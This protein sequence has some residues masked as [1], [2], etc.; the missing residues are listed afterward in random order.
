MLHYLPWHLL[1]TIY[2]SHVQ[3]LITRFELCHTSLDLYTS[4]NC[5][6]RDLR[7]IFDE[8]LPCQLNSNINAAHIE[9]TL[10]PNF[11][12]N[13]CSIKTRLSL[14]NKFRDLVCSWRLCHFL[15]YTANWA[16]PQQ[17][18]LGQVVTCRCFYRVLKCDAFMCGLSMFDS[19][20][21]YNNGN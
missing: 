7:H 3:L 1:F 9:T 19:C 17:Y 16:V 18:K 13:S 12:C 21:E 15:V 2:Y 8:P 11:K 14:V 20:W 10:P 6:V 4:L 5:C